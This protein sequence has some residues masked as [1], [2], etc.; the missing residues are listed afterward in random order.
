MQSAFVDSLPPAEVA[1]GFWG[2]IAAALLHAEDLAQTGWGASTHPRLIR[3]PLRSLPGHWPGA[4]SALHR[5]AA[6]TAW[7]DEAASNPR[8]LFFR[9]TILAVAR[10]RLARLDLAAA[11]RI[12]ELAEPRRDAA[13]RW[14]LAAVWTVRARFTREED[15]W[16]KVR[17][18]LADAASRRFLDSAE[19]RSSS[20]LAARALADP[21]DRNLRLAV[22]LIGMGRRQEAADRLARV[23]ERPA[24]RLQVPR[25]LLE[26]EAH[27]FRGQLPRAT[28]L[29]RE[30]SLLAPDSQVVIAALVAA[31]QAAGLWDE[32]AALANDR[33]RAGERTLPWADF[34]LTWA[35]TDEPA[36]DW[37]RSLVRG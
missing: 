7:G 4:V 15:L 12:L 22:A 2:R 8:E 23:S 16:P 1:S 28:V 35:S 27:R 36:L 17:D 21:D 32:A 11:S 10:L 3:D 37:L 18:L 5:D 25:L 14:Q 13:L 24:P 19:G 9:E 29:L 31:L 30:A 26:A 33:L 20:R 6:R 34:L